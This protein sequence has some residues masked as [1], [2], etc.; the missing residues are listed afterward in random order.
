MACGV[1]LRMQPI[2]GVALRIQQRAI[3]PAVYRIEQQR[4]IEREWDRRRGRWPRAAFRTSYATRRPNV[5]DGG[6]TAA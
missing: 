3:Q 1:L 6:R 4:L 5:P 2:A